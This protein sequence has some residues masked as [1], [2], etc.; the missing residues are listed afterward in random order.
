M[1]AVLTCDC[2][3]SLYRMEIDI[4]GMC[5]YWVYTEYNNMCELV[6]RDIYYLHRVNHLIIFYLDGD[7]EPGVEPRLLSN[8]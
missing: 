4:K 5:Y 1:T 6:L 8:R 7:P 2:F 3:V